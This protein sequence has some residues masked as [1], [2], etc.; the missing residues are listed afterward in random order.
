MVF[1]FFKGILQPNRGVSAMKFAGSEKGVEHSGILCSSMIATE[2]E[3]LSPQ[4]HRANRILNF[5]IIEL[6]SAITKDIFQLWILS[7]V[8]S[9]GLPHG[10]FR[11]DMDT[12]LIVP[13]VYLLK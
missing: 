7:Q 13:V 8:I 3:V 5:I 11:Q 4:S 12:F 10:T 9:H 6:N 1:D 2:Q